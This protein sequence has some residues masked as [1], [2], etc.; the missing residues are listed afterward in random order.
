MPVGSSCGRRPR[1]GICRDR[2]VAGQHNSLAYVRMKILVAY[3]IQTKVLRE[4][5][6]EQ[7]CYVRL[8][9]L[10][11]SSAMTS[12]AE[13]LLFIKL[14]CVLQ[15]YSHG[16]NP[17]Y[18]IKGKRRLQIKNERRQKG[19]HREKSDFEFHT[20]SLPHKVY[21]IRRCS[22]HQ[23]KNDENSSGNC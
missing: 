16:T 23:K 2:A 5:Y 12:C 13:T 22:P 8:S 11:I 21:L 20:S 17:I 1:I 10:L 3:D 7:F 9:S 15:F 4:H 18:L 6:I 19:L 14:H